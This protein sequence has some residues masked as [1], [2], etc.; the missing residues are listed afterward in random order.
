MLILISNDDGINAPGIHALAEAATGLG[1]VWVCAPATEQS[2]K[3]HGLTMHDPLRVHEHGPRWFSI[4]GTPA[5]ATYMGLVHILPRMPDIV[6]SGINRGSNLG[7]DVH[8]SG[9][10]AAAR[11]AALK[12]LPAL[13][14]SLYITDWGKQ[15]PFHYSDAAQVTIEVARALLADPL[16]T[17]IFLNLNVPDLPRDQIKGVRSAAIGERLYESRVVTSRDPRGKPYYWIGGP[18][19]GFAGAPD[20]DG[21]LLEAGFAAVSPLTLDPTAHHALGQVGAWFGKD[22]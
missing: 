18:S 22:R 7:S 4:T 20:T 8:Y 11:E 19:R 2:A 16:P 5:D 6:I 14:T 1:E 21:K 17:G 3:S 13:A 10:V 15:T 9:T 12:G